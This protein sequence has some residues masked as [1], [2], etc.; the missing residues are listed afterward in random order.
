[1]EGLPRIYQALVTILLNLIL[2][3]SAQWS[4]VT[5]NKVQ[6]SRTWVGGYGICRISLSIPIRHEFKKLS[7]CM[8]D[9]LEKEKDGM[10][11]SKRL[12]RRT[13]DSDT[14]NFFDRSVEELSV[15]DFK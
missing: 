5:S 4:P 13:L 1:M 7:K 15:P 12:Q 14:S 3:R 11:I 9:K 2:R 10:L 6:D 8:G